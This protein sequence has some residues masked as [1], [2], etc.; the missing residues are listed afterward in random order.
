MKNCETK[1]GGEQIAVPVLCHIYYS[2][3]YGTKKVAT[4]TRLKGP[5]IMVAKNKNGLIFGCGTQLL[6]LTHNDFK[7]SRSINEK[8]HLSLAKYR[9][10]FAP[11]ILANKREIFHSK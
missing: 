1:I 8:L 6:F 5:I 9:L 11:E 3:F 2:H 7:C 4:Y 10:R